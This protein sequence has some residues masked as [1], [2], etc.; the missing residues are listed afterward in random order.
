[1][2]VLAFVLVVMTIVSL[3]DLGFGRLIFKVFG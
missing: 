3:L 2:V 1:V